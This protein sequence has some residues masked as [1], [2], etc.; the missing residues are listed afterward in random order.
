MAQVLAMVVAVGSLVIAAFGVLWLVEALRR[1]R[2]LEEEFLLEQRE[3]AEHWLR[4]EKELDPQLPVRPRQF[5]LVADRTTMSLVVLIVVSLGVAATT[6]LIEANASDDAS[7]G[8]SHIQPAASGSG[9]DDAFTGLVR[10]RD[11]VPK[12]RNGNGLC[13]MRYTDRATSKPREGGKWWTSCKTGESLLTVEDVKELLALPARFGAVRDARTKVTIPAGTR[14]SYR[15][16]VTAP[17]CEEEVLPPECRGHVYA[18]GGWQY[19]FLDPARTEAWIVAV[20]CSNRREDQP[21]AW[22]PC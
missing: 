6:S 1:R 5:L 2:R 18:G 3:Q 20:E 7:T 8:P 15:E 10:T 4:R 14:V 12:R 13:L 9:D 11:R 17:Q 19:A 22:T 16:G 21:S